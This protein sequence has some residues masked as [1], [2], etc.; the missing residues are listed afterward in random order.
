MYMRMRSKQHRQLYRTVPPTVSY[1]R[2]APLLFVQFLLSGFVEVKRWQDIRQP[3]SQAEPGSFLGFESSLKGK[4]VGYPGGPFDPL[5][6]SKCAF[7][8]SNERVELPCSARQPQ[9]N[10]AS[11]CSA[12]DKIC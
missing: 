3:G 8:H 7:L 9:S 2:A 1:S 4:E 11:V 12:P 10:A 6:L 5:G